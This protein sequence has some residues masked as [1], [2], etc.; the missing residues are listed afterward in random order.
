MTEAGKQE[1]HRNAVCS[2]RG[3]LT[4]AT[5]NTRRMGRKKPTKNK[6]FFFAFRTLFGRGHPEQLSP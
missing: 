4:S 3:G 6:T 5:F 1:K 2:G